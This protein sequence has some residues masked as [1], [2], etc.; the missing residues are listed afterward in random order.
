LAFVGPRCKHILNAAERRGFMLI[1]SP[2]QIRQAV[3]VNEMTAAAIR[4]AYVAAVDGRASLPPVG[5]LAFPDHDGDCHVK[6]DHI[7]GQPL[8]VVKIA[9]GFYGNPARGLPTSN[10]VMVAFSAVEG[11]PI[12]VLQ[13]AGWL[14][15]LRT[16]IG[17]A[18]AT[19]AL[20][21][22]G[23]RH[24]TVIGA[25]MQARLQA[26]ALAKLAPGPLSFT[27]WAR[28]V[29]RAAGLAQV[30]GAQGLDV[31]S[32]ADAETACRGADVIVTSTP[33][34]TAIVQ[35]AWVGPGTH[36]TAM[37]ADAP[38]KQELAVDLV[39]G[40][41]LL[42]ADLPAQCLDHGEF[43][44]AFDA[45]W[46]TAPQV[47]ALGDVLRGAVTGRSDDAQI[48]IADLT[49]LAT[50]DIAIAACVLAQRDQKRT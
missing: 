31:R 7:A 15:E 44:A 12:A 48:T 3:D 1:L 8:F 42:V 18:V 9:T 49:G 26:E 47:V 14:T 43:R 22:S 41:D 28:D 25:G 5:F 17:G 39:A 23:F 35:A 2:E 24:V 27:I 10:G 20:A 45:G 40:A 21:R 6:F 30:L 29:G 16:A 4:D 37:G 46:I 32:M 13:D 38:G 36:I 11:H 33:S 19:L 50:Q 34:R